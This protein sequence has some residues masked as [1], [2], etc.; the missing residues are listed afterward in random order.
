LLSTQQRPDPQHHLANAERLDHI[1]V[2]THFKTHDSVDLLTLGGQHQDGD[3][4]SA[5]AG[6][7]LAAHLDARDIREHQVEHH[8]VRDRVLVR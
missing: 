8:G 1:V 5:F 3:V 7:Q 6:A 2:R 4:L